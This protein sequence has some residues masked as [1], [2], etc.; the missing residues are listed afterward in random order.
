M[1]QVSLTE[2]KKEANNPRINSIQMLVD[3]KLL[4]KGFVLLANALPILT[5]L[6]MAIHFTDT[7]LVNSLSTIVRTLLGST[8]LMGGALVL[9]NWYDADIDAMMERTKNRPT[10]TGNFSLRL[11]FKM[12]VLLSVLGLIILA[13]TSLA[14]VT[15]SFIGWFTYVVLYTMWTKRKY[16]WNTIIGS[17]SGAVTPLIGWSAIAP[18]TDIVPIAMVITLFV[19]QMPHTYAIAIKKRQEYKT[20]GVKM[21]PVTHGISVTKKHIFFYLACLLPLSFLFYPLG[22]LFIIFASLLAITG[23]VLVCSGY[24]SDNETKWANR[25]FLFSVNYVTFL[26]IMMIIATMII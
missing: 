9:N 3:L 12:G 21:L 17:V 6:I 18:I 16:T 14:T 22:S 10:V 19:W 11:V 5:G 2:T 7:T 4:F 25:I 1:K 13:F 23:L 15:I 20:A 26:F 24:Y 8:L